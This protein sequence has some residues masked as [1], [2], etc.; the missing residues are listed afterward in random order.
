MLHSRTPGAGRLCG[1]GPVTRDPWALVSCHT[2][3]TL[4]P[5]KLGRTSTLPECLFSFP[6]PGSLPA[7]RSQ[8]PSQ[9]LRTEVKLQCTAGCKRAGPHTGRA[10]KSQTDLAKAGAKAQGEECGERRWTTGWQA[11]PGLLQVIR[12]CQVIQPQAGLEIMR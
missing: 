7:A 2:M 8:A 4:V 6:N 12:L 11:P 10:R 9:P 3:T 1:Y 5:S